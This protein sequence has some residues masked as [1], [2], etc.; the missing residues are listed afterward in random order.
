MHQIRSRRSFSVIIVLIL[1][2]TPALL[3]AHPHT[4]IDTQ[5]RIV[6]EA[7]RL[8]GLQ[9]TWYFDP[10]FTGSILHDFDTDSDGKF[11]QAEVREIQ[12]Y[13]FSN[14]VNYDYFTFIE[15]GDETYVPEEIEGFIAYMEGKT[16]VYR[17][18][19]PFDISVPPEGVK[20]AIYDDTF[21][22]DILYHE[23]SPVVIEGD[24]PAEWE[25]VENRDKEINYG[26][27]VS[28]ARESRENS[29]AAYPQQVVLVLK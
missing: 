12:T 26:G 19:S 25:I 1:L 23:E 8:K 18:F 22:C 16:L 14:L 24:T 28:V 4:F 17:F 9:I 2:R 27:P 10:M 6:V 5:M 7:E 29:G 20:I 15:V 21:F 3:S 11:G 13:A